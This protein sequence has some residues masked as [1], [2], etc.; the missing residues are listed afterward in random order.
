MFIFD[1]DISTRSCKSILIY[2]L[3]YI[4]LT[5]PLFPV[6]VQN[7]LHRESNTIE[8]CQADSAAD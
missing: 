1:A 8:A 2:I 6:N 4:Q 3:N 5:L 7:F